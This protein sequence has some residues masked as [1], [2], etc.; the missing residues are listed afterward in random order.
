MNT[1]IYK[2]LFGC[3]PVRI[4]IALIAK[5]LDVDYLPIMAIFTSII[6]LG[7]FNAYLKNSRVGFFGGDVW[8]NNYRLVHS[9]IFGLFSILA[10]CKHPDS[11]IVLLVDVCFGLLFFINN[12]ML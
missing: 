12:Y 9:I 5:N 3:L 1:I 10:F 8:W 6:S 7:F 4:S 11:W 2:F